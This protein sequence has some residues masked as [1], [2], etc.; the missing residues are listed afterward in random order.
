MAAADTAWSS[1]QVLEEE[2]NQVVVYTLCIPE[3]QRDRIS[4]PT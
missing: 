3:E 2:R 4:I 1:L